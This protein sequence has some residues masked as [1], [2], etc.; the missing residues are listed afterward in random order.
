MIHKAELR[1]GNYIKFIGK[2]SFSYKRNEIYKYDESIMIDLL[3]NL[4]IDHKD[5]D[6]ILLN[7]DWFLKF[8]FVKN[9]ARNYELGDFNI[10][11]SD[12][13]AII[14]YGF[15]PLAAFE[16]MSVHQLQNLYFAI[17]GKEL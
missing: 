12:N 3:V 10:R 13:T 15:A 8:G 9:R 14:I 6:P 11:I 7:E 4:S 2:R 5:F 16:K 17:T 1:I